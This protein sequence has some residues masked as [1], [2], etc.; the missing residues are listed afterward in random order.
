M[1]EVRGWHLAMS[2]FFRFMHSTCTVRIDGNAGEV[3][4]MGQISINNGCMDEAIP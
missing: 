3:N 4:I 1:T 2:G